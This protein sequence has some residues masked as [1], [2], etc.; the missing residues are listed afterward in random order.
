MS[1]IDKEFGDGMETYFAGGVTYIILNKKDSKF[2]VIKNYRGEIAT[3][4]M[5][6]L[7]F[8]WKVK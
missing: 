7:L 3:I 6:A 4:S 8:N 1:E 2:Y 5:G